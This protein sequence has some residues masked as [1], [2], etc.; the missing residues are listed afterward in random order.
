MGLAMYQVPEGWE[1]T[2]F[3]GHKHL[4]EI[5]APNKAGF[6]TVD[7]GKR[8]FRG[9]Y[10]VQGRPDSTAEYVGRGWRDS[11]RSDAVAWLENIQQEVKAR[12][13]QRA[14]P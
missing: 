2:P 4:V 1:E 12:S 9:G 11:L 5:S 8:E 3:K 10:S 7:F 6:V 14:A 13:K